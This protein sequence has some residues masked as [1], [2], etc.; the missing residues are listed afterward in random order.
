MEIHIFEI[1]NIMKLKYDIAEYVSHCNIYTELLLSVS[2]DICTIPM[3]RLC[4][5]DQHQ[6]SKHQHSV[7]SCDIA[8][9][10]ISVV[11]QAFK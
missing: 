2:Y 11:K 5:L 8:L 3:R 1:E 7:F 4:D 10:I 9:Y 6:I